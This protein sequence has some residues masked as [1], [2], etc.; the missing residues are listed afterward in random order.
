MKNEPTNYP[1]LVISR[2]AGYC[3]GLQKKMLVACTGIAKQVIAENIAFLGLQSVVDLL[4]ATGLSADHPPFE[5][6]DAYGAVFTASDSVHP[7]LMLRGLCRL[8]QAAGIPVLALSGW[9]LPT[10]EGQFKRQT[11]APSNLT[12]PGMFD[13][14]A[15]FCGGAPGD[16]FEFGTFLGYTLQCAFHAFNSRGLANKR[17]FIAFD[18]FAGIVGSK[19]GEG[20]ADGGYAASVQSLKF[21]NFIAQVPASKVVMIE[22]PY[23]HTLVGAAAEATRA[24]VGETQAAVVHIDC[25]V[26]EPTKLALDFMT[27]YMR[28]GTLLLF[29]EFDVNQANNSKGER[30]A[31]RA[32]LKENPTFEVEPYRCYHVHARSFIVHKKT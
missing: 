30:A 14:V 24:T 15:R 5:V 21:A 32:W 28:Q 19:P 31:L 23:Q 18:S 17:R 8:Y 3:F 25:D 11:E 29:D 6:N 26:E 9:P 7:M 20:F 12:V 4:D 22:G 10:D 16:Y 13:L 27:P 1:Q 2:A